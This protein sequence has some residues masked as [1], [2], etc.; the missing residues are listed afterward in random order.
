MYNWIIALRCPRMLPLRAARQAVGTV[1][2][3]NKLKACKGPKCPP[4]N[5]EN[6]GMNSVHISVKA[7]RMR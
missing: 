2:I 3:V 4:I 7:M 6:D 1:Q 5:G